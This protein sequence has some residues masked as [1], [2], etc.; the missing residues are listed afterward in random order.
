MDGHSAAKGRLMNLLLSPAPVTCRRR[1]EY[2]ERKV[3]VESARSQDW[4]PAK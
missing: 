4:H 3:E 2:E 1:C